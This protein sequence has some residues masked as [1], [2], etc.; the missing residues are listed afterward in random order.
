MRSDR[1]D[2]SER[3]ERSARSIR[4]RCVMVVAAA[5]VMTA[6]V[7][8]AQTA[9]A[10]SSRT[11]AAAK[12]A[13]KEDVNR[14]HPDGSTPLQ[15]AVHDGNVAEVKRLLRL[16]ADLKVANNYRATPMSLA[17]EVGSTEML[18]VLLEA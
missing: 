16:G 15:W 6:S 11:S 14:R 2:R 13:A 9:A 18:K 3:S 8:N 17:A 1:S 7:G 12:P 5:L 10:R 4:S